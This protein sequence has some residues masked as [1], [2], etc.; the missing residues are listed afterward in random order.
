MEGS[1]DLSF[2]P[3]SDSLTLKGHL[4]PLDKVTIPDVFQL[5]P[6]VRVVQCGEDLGDSLNARGEVGGFDTLHFGG[7][8]RHLLGERG[9]LLKLDLLDGLMACLNLSEQAL[10]MLLHQGFKLHDR[11][12]V[13]LVYVD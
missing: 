6:F 9:K 8:K 2:N 1:L 4:D 11:W 7:Q 3:V 13:A 12:L 10:R 5:H